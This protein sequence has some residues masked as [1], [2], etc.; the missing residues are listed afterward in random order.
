MPADSGMAFVVVLHLDPTRESQLA[1]ILDQQ[2]AMPVAEIADGMAI[3][4]DH[5]YVIAP[6]SS[7]TVDDGRLRLSE[8]AEPRGHRR[9]VD[10]LFAS[11]AEDR[12]ERAICVVLSGTGNNGTHGLK[13]V[14][15]LG[16]C[17]LVQDPAT[18]RFDGMPRSA[19]AAGLADQVPPR[20][21]CRTS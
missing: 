20:R 19:I 13:D 11:L 10:I 5:V 7:L 9:P 3:E 8:A 18:A 1:H 2:T 16:G 17:T 4:P 14:K 6:D 12:R 15:A 21:K